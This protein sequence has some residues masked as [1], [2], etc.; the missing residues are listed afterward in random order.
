MTEFLTWNR[1]YPPAEL[2]P[3]MYYTLV[4]MELIWLVGILSWVVGK[5]L[6]KLEVDDWRVLMDDHLDYIEGHLPKNC[7]CYYSVW[8]GDPPT[9]AYC[10]AAGGCTNCSMLTREPNVINSEGENV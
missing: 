10:N 4:V 7:G 3:F 2:S 5:V 8:Y 6:K 1:W 9:Y